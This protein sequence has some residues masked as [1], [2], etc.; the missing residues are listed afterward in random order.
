MKKMMTF[1]GSL[2]LGALLLGMAACSNDENELGEAPASVSG[3]RLSFTV[4]GDD[5]RTE[6][7]ADGK[8][9]LWNADDQVGVWYATAQ[10]SENNGKNVWVNKN[11]IYSIRSLSEGGSSA[12]FTGNIELNMAKPDAEHKFYVYYPYWDGAKSALKIPGTLPSVQNYDTEAWDLSTLDF[13]YSGVCRADLAQAGPE[14]GVN[15]TVKL[16]HLFAILRLAITNGTGSGFTI[17]KVTLTSKGG[18]MLAGDYGVSISLGDADQALP[19]VVVASDV[20]AP[21]FTS[22][23]SSVTVHV[24]NGTVAAGGTTDVRMMLNAGL[25]SGSAEEFYLD[26]DTFCVEVVSDRGVWTTEFAAGR[27]ARGGRAVKKLTVDTFAAVPAAENIES[28][29]KNGNFY[30]NAAATVTG[31][32]L[33]SV[34]GVTV[35][36]IAVENLTVDAGKLT[37]GIPDGVGF[38]TA[39][40]CD[41]VATA[42]D[43]ASYNLGHITVYPFYHYTDIKLGSG[44]SSKTAYPYPEFAWTNAFF[45][46]DTGRVISTDEWVAA[47]IDPFAK[48]SSSNAAIGS[49][50]TLNKDKITAEEYYAISPYIFLTAGSDGKLA[51]QNPANSASQLK[52]HRYEEGKTSV[53]TTYGTPV[54]FY[55]VLK[56]GEEYDAVK[57]GSLTT[58]ATI[59]KVAGSSAPAFGDSRNFTVGDVLAVHYVT[60]TKGAKP[61]AAEDVHKQGYMVVTE[62][63]CGDAAAGKATDLNGHVKFDF[64][65]SQTLNE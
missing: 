7:A 47:S 3:P 46:P 51:F 13:V 54:I 63:T 45:L 1:A 11:E 64:Y 39:T 28:D 8:S 22:V 57:A 61:A 65:W 20:T 44:S 15:P 58:L 41:V 18:L 26:G 32:N 36:G 42:T 19:N 34:T 16:M 23:S 6:L 59:G 29:D 50:S 62:V 49:S 56:S 38:D 17:S 33:S 10:P 30:L 9:V 5:S 24:A 37:F 40:E 35:G 55:Q 12:T 43:G 48:L 21:G 53:A 14:L 31:S 2:F 60:Y 27:L 52:A 25:K 4:T